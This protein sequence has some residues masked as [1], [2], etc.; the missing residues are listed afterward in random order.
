MSRPR[1]EKLGQYLH[2]T[3]C[4]NYVTRGQP[5]F[6]PLFKV[7]PL[8][9]IFRDQ[10]SSMHKPGCAI[11][12]DEAM[13]EF[14]GR[15]FFK[16]YISQSQHHGE[17]KCGARK[18]MMAINHAFFIMEASFKAIITVL[19]EYCVGFFSPHPRWTDPSRRDFYI[20]RVYLG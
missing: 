5:G 14:S 12:I 16:Q 4:S 13:T 19:H 9:E 3:D 17:S 8:M 15:L 2:L 11:S 7:R 18:K 6:D 20:Y 1:Y 10:R